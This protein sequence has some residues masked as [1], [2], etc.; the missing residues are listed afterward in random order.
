MKRPT[1]DSVVADRALRVIEGLT[2]EDIIMEPEKKLEKI[3]MFSHVG[4]GHCKNPHDDWR[5][6]LEEAERGLIEGGI[7]DEATPPDGDK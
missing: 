2:F 1:Y 4:N 5:K 6:L 3:Y 7:M